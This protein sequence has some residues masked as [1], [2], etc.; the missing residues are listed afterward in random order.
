MSHSCAEGCLSSVQPITGERADELAQEFL[1]LFEVKGKGKRRGA[2]VT[3]ARQ[4]PELLEKVLFLDSPRSPTCQTADCLGAMT[5][6]WHMRLCGLLQAAVYWSAQSRMICLDLIFSSCN[7]VRHC[8][9]RSSGSIFSGFKSAKNTSCGPLSQQ[10][11]Q[12]KMAMHVGRGY[13]E[14]T[15]REHLFC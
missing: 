1:D 14:P 15:C 12:T 10:V 13:A 7:Q 4:H 5:L 3:S 9:V 8:L 2:K 11:Q 6:V